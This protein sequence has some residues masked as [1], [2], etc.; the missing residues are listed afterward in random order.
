MTTSETK[1]P[2]KRM[3]FFYARDAVELD[4]ETM[5]REHLSEEVL[6]GLSKLAGIS[7]AK[8]VGEKSLLLFKEPGEQG[9]S[10][11]YLWLKS[12]YVLPPHRHDGDCLYYV[13][14]G[15]VQ[16]GSKTLRKG[17]GMFI[18]ADAGYSYQ[19]GPEGVEVLEFRNATHFNIALI[20]NEGGRWD[21]MASAFRERGLT[22]ET[23]TVPPS[24]R[25]RK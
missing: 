8:G 11:V 6:E 12:G 23:E 3:A 24:E 21:Q 1:P 7:V 18:P 17:D 5:S 19:A 14:G 13:V 2:R 25:S 20:G 4:S 16:I 10:L 9:M 15:E 22:W